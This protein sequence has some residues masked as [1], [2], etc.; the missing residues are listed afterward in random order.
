MDTYINEYAPLSKFKE[1]IYDEEG[2]HII[3]D[4]LVE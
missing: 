1:T 4:T 2:D 3:N